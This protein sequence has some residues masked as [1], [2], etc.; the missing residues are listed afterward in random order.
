MPGTGESDESIVIGA[1]YDKTNDGPAAAWD[2]QEGH[3]Q[4]I[5][6]AKLM[7]DYWDAKGARPTATVKF[8]PWDGRGVGHARLRALRAERHPAG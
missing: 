1:H 8:I 3:A 2:S 5:R 6:V 7:A 4:M